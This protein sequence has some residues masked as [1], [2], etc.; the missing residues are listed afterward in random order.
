MATTRTPG[1][2]IGAGGRYFIDK[3]YRG[4]RI[5]MRVGAITQEQAEHRLQVEMQR[6]DIDLQRAS[7]PRPLFRDCAVRYLAQ[8]KDKRSLEAI[9]I[10]VRLLLPHIGL[11]EPQ[12]V[13][14]A[15]LAPFIE[16]RIAGGASTTT[17]NRSLEVV[18]T[19]LT[20]ASRSYRDDDGHPWLEAIPPLITMLRESRRLPYPITWSEQDRLFPRL[21]EHLQRMVLFAVNT[22]LR[23]NNVCGLE[24]TWEVFVPEVARSVFIV[25]AE[26]FKSR[27]DHVVILN[28]AAWSI[29]QTQ[30]GLH[31]IWVFPFRGQRIGTMNNTGWQKAR[32][33]VG[34]RGVRIHD[35]RHTF[36]CRLRAAG[37]PAEDRAALL[38]HAEHSMSGHYASGDVGRLVEKANLALRRQETCTVL[39]LATAFSQPEPLAA[40][41]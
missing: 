23:D 7:H 6:V 36:A 35:L 27:R 11:L 17:V 4:V 32:R 9:R 2:T 34:L 29:V 28:D 26:A 21:P 22:G 40:C 31:P 16:E 8:C 18:R 38:G 37:V 33:A 39:R 10:H 1:I 20:R 19:I 30:R 15:T 5:G 12:Q 24:W 14:D 41:G 3:R 13:H 25:P